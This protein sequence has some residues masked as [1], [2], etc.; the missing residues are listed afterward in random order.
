MAASL[1]TSELVALSSVSASDLLLISDVA[2]SA[3]KKT[4]FSDFQSSISLAN[5]GTRSIANLSDV[6]TSGISDGQALIWQSAGSQFIPGDAV[7]TLDSLTDVSTSGA[8]SGDA[9]IYNGTS[10]E[11]GVP[12]IDLSDLSDVNAAGA[13]SGEALI[14][15]GT[16]F[17]PGA[18]DYNDLVNLPTI[19]NVDSL[20]ITDDTTDSIDFEILS[21]ATSLASASLADTDVLASIKRVDGAGSGLDADTVDGHGEDALAASFSISVD[22]DSADFTLTA[23]DG[24]TVLGTQSIGGATESAAGLVTTTTQSFAGAKT[25][26]SNVT[27]SGNLTVNGTSSTVNST[28]VTL[29]DTLVEV[30][31]DGGSAPT[32]ETTKDLG[33][34]GH[35]HDGTSAYKAAMFY[36]ESADEFVMH[37]NVTETDGVL[38]YTGQGADLR[39]GGL[40]GVQS[41]D[42]TTVATI[43]AAINLTTL[44]TVDISGTTVSSADD[45]LSIDLDVDVN[46][47]TDTLA[48]DFGAQ[49]LRT[50][51]GGRLDNSD[52]AAAA[53]I[54]DTKLATI[55]TADKVSVSAL[56]IDGATAISGDLAGTDLIVVDDGAAGTNVK[57]TI[58]DVS[59]YVAS[60]NTVK[61]LAA[62]STSADTEPTNYYFLVVDAS[63]GTLKAIDKTFIEAEQSN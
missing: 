33:I 26:A 28:I 44:T 5:L 11:P 23:A 53:G 22:T 48:L 35:Y 30:G 37:D 10:W 19:Q 59:T 52:I 41:L 17:L 54:V 32:S 16:Q 57:A 27:I 29:D 25:F 60:D 24:S 2:N 8:A 46:G 58:D 34:V 42:A 61:D 51:I 15:D 12:S 62:L 1:K 63:D 14:Y 6:V 21:G 56:N 3:S 55:S 47:V 9:L 49:D 13:N 4:T 31:T 36:D 38:S 20:T 45:N 39:V 18:Y 7:T 40:A 43:E 50:A